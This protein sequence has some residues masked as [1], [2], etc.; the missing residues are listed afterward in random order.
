MFRLGLLV[1]GQLLLGAA[2]PSR[3]QRIRMAAR[4]WG[5]L[6][7][8]RSAVLIV[9]ASALLFGGG[10]KWLL[11][12]RA[13]RALDRVDE[14]NVTPAEIA[15][16]AGHGRSVAMDLFRIL[17][18]STDPKFRTAAGQGLAALWA[19]DQLVA[20]EEKAIVTRGFVATWRARRRY[21]RAMRRPIPMAVEYGVP[22]LDDEGDRVRAQNLE[23]S[24]RVIG[25]ERASLETFSP[26]TAG[27]GLA[28]F[29]IEPR[30]FNSN[31]PHRLVL[32]TRV[33][34]TGLTSKWELELPHVPFSFE[35]DPILAVDALLTMPDE[36]RG[37]AIARAIR[38]VP[39]ETGGET[40]S[41]LDL[42]A[43][44]ALRDP[45]KLVANTP[46]PCDLAHALSLEF[47]GMPGPFPAGTVTLSGQG[48]GAAGTGATALALGPIKQF[49]D[50][51]IER[52][53]TYRVRAILSPDPDQ[54][55]A[56]P[57]VRSIW[58][59]KIVTEWRE[60]R[61]VRK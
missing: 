42:N 11:A 28:R 44:W 50:A 36:P 52:P 12:L 60:V 38:L 4:R 32:Q 15:E 37:A 27:P 31:G 3:R 16:L 1:V 61:I 25:T 20:E 59:D 53:G 54:G 39:P 58:P 19:R 7:D 47:E 8:P 5:W 30:D 21:P 33:R 57:N 55:W 2:P 48:E 17:G 46:L 56:D 35:F 43:E 41:Y 24:H 14:S 26:W 18:T 23:W 40:S 49:G 9:L 34:T 13:R 22:F 29:E 6:G 10:R 45:P 51:V